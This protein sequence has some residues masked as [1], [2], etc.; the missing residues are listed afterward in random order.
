MTPRSDLEDRSASSTQMGSSAELQMILQSIEISREDSSLVVPRI[1]FPDF[2]R[3]KLSALCVEGWSCHQ[4]NAARSNQMRERGK[5]FQCQRCGP[6]IAALKRGFAVER[7]EVGPECRGAALGLRATF[8]SVLSHRLGAKPAL[9]Q[10]P[11]YAESQPEVP[12]CSHASL[13][14]RALQ[15]H[16]EAF[17]VSHWWLPSYPKVAFL[18]SPLMYQS[19]CREICHHHICDSFEEKTKAMSPGP[20]VANSTWMTL[21]FRLL[22]IQIAWSETVVGIAE[23][24]QRL[25]ILFGNL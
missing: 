18:T 2:R 9:H 10:A 20:Q 5:S 13:T 16:P 8:H 7:G 24:L 17:L 6:H 22:Q 19:V 12:A 15:C 1:A 3:G 21:A 11:S 4:Y 23:N 25:R 14:P